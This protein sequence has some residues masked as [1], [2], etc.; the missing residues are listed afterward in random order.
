MSEQ[1]GITKP[2]L[3]DAQHPSRQKAIRIIEQVIEPLLKK[4]INGQKYY[5]LEDQLTLIINGKE[6]YGRQRKRR[7]QIRRR[8]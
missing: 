3:Y 2:N 1:T 8:Q 4:G 5:A 6:S 7:V